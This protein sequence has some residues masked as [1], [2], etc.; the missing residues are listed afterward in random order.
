MVTYTLLLQ[1]PLYA[2]TVLS[3]RRLTVEVSDMP[4]VVKEA[5]S[6]SIQFIESVLSRFEKGLFVKSLSYTPMGV[7]E[8]HSGL[9]TIK[10]G[11]VHPHVMDGPTIDNSNIDHADSE[12]IRGELSKMDSFFYDYALDSVRDENSKTGIKLEGL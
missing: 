5:L 7:D 11:R 10:S 9:F 4:G 6:Q 3:Q 1:D 8:K 12:K 2:E